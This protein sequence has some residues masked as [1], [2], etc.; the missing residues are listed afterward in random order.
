MTESGD[1]TRSLGGAGKDTSSK[2][3]EEERDDEEEDELGT[4]WAPL[5]REVYDNNPSVKSRANKTHAVWET[6]KCLKKRTAHDTTVHPKYT[7]VCVDRITTSKGGENGPDED[8]DG[9]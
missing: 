3:G 5:P 6:V 1:T 8:G 9:N 7:H 4:T 2:D